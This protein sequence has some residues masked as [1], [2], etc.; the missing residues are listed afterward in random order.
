MGFLFVIF[1]LFFLLTANTSYS[2]GNASSS[3][4]FNPYIVD[5]SG[6][7]AV[8][9]NPVI[10]DCTLQGCHDGIEKFIHEQ[11]NQCKIDTNKVKIGL[12]LT[13]DTPESPWSVNLYA[14][15]IPKIVLNRADAMLLYERL[16][17][18]QQSRLSKK[19]AEY[20]ARDK[21]SIR[22]ELGHIHDQHTYYNLFGAMGILTA[23]TTFSLTSLTGLSK[24]LSRAGLNDITNGAL[25]LL[26]SVPLA[27]ALS[28]ATESVY[29]QYYEARADNFA[30]QH[31]HDAAELDAWANMLLDF[32]NTENSSCLGKISQFIKGDDTHPS[33]Y[34]RYLKFK[35]AA[36]KLKQL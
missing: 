3:A 14:K 6:Q 21:V 13:D 2:T 32:H 36:D 23:T 35:N 24:I 16:Q 5:C 17:K 34:S 27:L 15:P 29:S 9:F 30:I 20:L 19:E 10:I 4:A 18:E 12:E 26:S 8:D 1:S 28:G 31:T 7:T 22:H 33:Y 11:A 25:I